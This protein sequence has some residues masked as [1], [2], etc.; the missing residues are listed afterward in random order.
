M[1]WSLYNIT[2]LKNSVHVLQFSLLEE[3]RGQ[4]GCGCSAQCKNHLSLHVLVQ[5]EFHCHIG[6]S[7]VTC[8]GRM[9]V[10]TNSSKTSIIVDP[11]AYITNTLLAFYAFSKC[12]Q[13]SVEIAA[14]WELYL[15]HQHTGM[16]MQISMRSQLKGPS[17]DILQALVCH[18]GKSRDGQEVGERMTDCSGIYMAFNLN[19][20][21]IITTYILV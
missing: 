19:N 12:H 2:L 5:V 17:R 13:H 8:A 14:V 3:G 18:A 20:I 11:H 1:N 7:I 6:Y 16:T 10:L 15:W 9:I 21:H 4:H